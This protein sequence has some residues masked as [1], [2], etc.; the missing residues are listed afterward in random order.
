MKPREV[1]AMCREKEVKAVDLRFTDFLGAWQHFTIPVGKL[2]EDV[3]EDG[4]GFDGSSIRGWQAINES[5]MLLVPVPGTAFVDPFA[6]LPT[7]AM[8]CMIQDPISR[9]DYS[10]DPR[11]I[12]RKAVNYLKSTGIA[13]TCFIGPE[14]EFFLFDDVRFD[15]NAHE[16]YYHLDSREA[17]WNRGRAEAPNL[18]YKLR[19]K[20]GYFPCPPADQLMD[21]RNEM[22]QT[23]IQCGIDVEAQHHEVA[24]GGQC[25][26][27]M[28]F[29]D[30][31]K[32]ADQMCLYKYLVRNVARRHG[33]TATF[34]PKPLYGDNGSGMHTHIS[35]WKDG[36]P[37][38]AGSGYAGLSETALHAIGGILRHA[39]AILAITNPTTNSYKRL[40]PGYEAPVNLA[41]SQRNRSASCRI[42]MYSASP[43]T[44]RVEF[45]CPDPTCNPYLAFAAILMAAIDGIQNKIHPGD[46]LDRDIYDMP[47][48]EL[49]NVPKAPGSLAEA[50]DALQRDGEFLLRGDVFTEDVIRTWVKWKREKE[51]DAMRLRPH[52]YECCLY[53]D[54]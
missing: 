33:R 34:M 49:A 13:D 44:K 50:L 15:Q 21:L 6:Q 18:G 40:V 51:I 46:P 23:M 16:G 3:F 29:Q 42:P 8:I 35:L 54:A 38:F 1:L 22:M 30:L 11:N 12:A 45:R 10:R 53:F 24:T 32:M 9:E 5:D 19:Y 31:V 43:K 17:E 26:I 39:P 41:Y 7:L 28:R 47:P 36:H 52:P 2:E 27:D 25:E 37:L 14:A 20:E 4:L 48:E